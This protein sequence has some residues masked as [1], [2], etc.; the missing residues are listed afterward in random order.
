MPENQINYDFTDAQVLVTGGTSG[1]GLA[2]ARAFH[3]AGAAVTVTG[4]RENTSQY[5]HDLS[6]F[7][8]MTMQASS[9]ENIE[10]V[11]ASFD[12]LDILINNAG[13]VFPDGLNESSPE[14]FE[15]SLRL[16]L[17]SAHIMSNACFEL[18]KQSTLIGG[19]SI[20]GIASLTS[21]RGMPFIPGY[22]AAKAALVQLAKSLAIGW[23][24]DNIRVN[25][26]AA[27]LI[28][29]RLTQGQDTPTTDI[30]DFNRPMIE[31]TPMQRWGMPD[32]IAD[33]VLFLS[34]SGARF[35]TGE[36]LVVDGGYC[37]VT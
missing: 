11:A 9:R 12:H 18:L 25:N 21:F 22:G 36:T 29:S 17:M 35:I 6:P 15:A 31:R 24:G 30:D 3:A 7:K 13:G 26:V 8:F 28:A 4:T 14:G 5:S 16:N 10:T 2:I 19:A 34:S 37:A 33:A 20:I 23:A 1:I 32:E 27:G